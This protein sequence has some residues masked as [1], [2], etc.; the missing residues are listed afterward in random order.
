[1][2]VSCVCLCVPSLYLE[3]IGAGAAE[4]VHGVVGARPVVLARGGQAG[5]AL[6]LDVDVHGPCEAQNTPRTLRSRTHTDD[7]LETL[8]LTAV[9][10]PTL[11]VKALQKVLSFQQP[12]P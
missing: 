11:V 7:Y 1:M 2:Y 9:Q 8:G 4:V 6:S 12:R 5:V 3:P 10:D